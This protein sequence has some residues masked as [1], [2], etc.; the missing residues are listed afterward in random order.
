MTAENLVD[1]FTQDHRT[2][3]ETWIAVENAAEAGDQAAMAS[4]YAKFRGELMHHLK[5]E[6]EVLFPAF[7]EATGM[8]QGPTAMM[9]IEHDQMR[10]VLGQMD[11]ACAG[12]D[13]ETLTDLG[14]TLLMIIQQHNAK[15]EGMLY[16]M[17]NQH[18]PMDWADLK[19]RIDAL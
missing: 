6:E 11:T 17:A 9:R 16:P 19:A 12:G 15:E 7:E 3:D 5:M 18:I 10:G 14:D 13:G 1:F 2:C 4:T 8:T